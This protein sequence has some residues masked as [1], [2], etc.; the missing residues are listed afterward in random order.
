MNIEM[1]EK[2][3]FYTFNDI[4]NATFLYFEKKIFLRND[5]NEMLG[6]V[7]AKYPSNSK[8]SAIIGDGILEFFLYESQKITKIYG[9][10]IDKNSLIFKVTK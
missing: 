7:W 8:L 10:D 6:T 5:T 4:M 9:K 3:E 2:E 1:T